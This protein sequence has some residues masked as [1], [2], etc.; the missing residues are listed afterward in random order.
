MR[1]ITSSLWSADQLPDHARQAA[2]LGSQ[3]LRHLLA[4][5]VR[6]VVAPRPAVL[7]APGAREEPLRLEPAEQ[8]IQR[9]LVDV[10]APV[11]ERLLERVA[12]LL[13]PQLD[14]N[15]QDQGA[16]PEFEREGV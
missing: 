3:F 11:R 6:L 15:R 7:D 13:A 12:I 9:A 2:P 4:L 10:E 1:S 16:P 8:G 14:E 5:R